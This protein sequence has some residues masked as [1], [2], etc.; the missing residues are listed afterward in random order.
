[1]S[2]GSV[3]PTGLAGPIARERGFLPLRLAYALY[4][5]SLL[6]TL[7][8][9]AVLGIVFLPGLERRRRVARWGARAFLR[10]AGMPL[11]VRFAERLPAGQCVVVAN[12]CS[13]LDGLVFKAALPP[14]FG[15]VIKR[16]MNSVPLV[17]LL[18]RRIGSL[19]VDRHNRH[20][21][22]A[23]ARRV[24]RTAASGESL[25]FFPEGTFSHTP[26]LLKFHS[27]AFAIAARAG[28]PVVP[29]VLR[30]TRRALPPASAL[31]CPGRLELE[32]LPPVVPLASAPDAATV[33]LRER[34]RVAILVCL[35]EPDAAAA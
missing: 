12:H 24:L 29:V 18:L 34:A 6:L 31:P 21:G 2:T 23:D 15:F 16:E 20:R 33:E 14:R 1:M 11:T 8:V 28:C 4:A 30:G 7:G 22:G 32:I 35:G 26:G 3:P 27:G 19:F 10:A 25:V 9:F 13:Y 5:W 17:G